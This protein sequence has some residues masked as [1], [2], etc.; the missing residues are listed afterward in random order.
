M[1]TTPNEPVQEPEYDPAQPGEPTQPGEDP[2]TPDPE[3]ED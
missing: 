3:G 2:G 1:T